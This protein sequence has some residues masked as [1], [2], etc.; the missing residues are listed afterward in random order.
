M[1]VLVT[2]AIVVIILVAVVLALAARRPNEF[3]VTRA[4]RIRATPDRIYP[5]I[6]DF[7]RWAAWSPWEKIDPAMRRS[8]SGAPTGTGSVY[9]WQGNSKAG[10]G[11]MEITQVTP[12][13]S[14]TVKL[15]FLKP[16]EAH[17]TVTFTLLPIGDSTDVTWTMFGPSPFM[18][19]VMGVFFNMDKLVGTDFERGLANLKAVA[20]A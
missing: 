14:V 13:T 8:Y 18:T 16:F 11:R 15:D 1:A 4:V 7:H 5:H 17:N 3:T 2:I 6:V 9:E 12:P 19:K 20:E 10:V